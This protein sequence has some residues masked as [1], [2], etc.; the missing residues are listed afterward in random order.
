LLQKAYSTI[1]SKLEEV[2]KYVVI[3]LQYQALWDMEANTL[4]SQLGTDLNK[5]QQLLGEIKRARTTFDNSATRKSF[6]PIIIDYAQVQ[7]SVNNK[8]DYWH[9]VNELII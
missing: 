5:W 6:G 9:K 7:A 4:Y 8:Y 2:Q 1:E 3:W